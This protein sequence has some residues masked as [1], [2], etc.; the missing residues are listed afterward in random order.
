MNTDKRDEFERLLHEKLGDYSEEPPLGIYSRVESSLAGSGAAVKD[1]GDKSHRTVWLY[2]MA[3]AAVVGLAVVSSLVFM[4]DG[5]EIR[6]Q[7]S[8]YVAE[9][10]AGQ[11]TSQESPVPVMSGDALVNK[12]TVS[13]KMRSMLSDTSDVVK[14][15]NFL[16]AMAM[17]IPELPGEKV[18]AE[19]KLSDGE[20]S[21]SVKEAMASVETTTYAANN[22]SR[23]ARARRKAARNASR[24][25]EIEDYW[26]NVF[27]EDD[28]ATVRK[29]RRGGMSASLYAGNFGAMQGNY[30]ASGVVPVAINGMAIDNTP[31]MLAA[32]APS[33]MSVSGRA[34]L[35]PAKPELHHKMPVSLG[36][37]ISIPMGERWSVVTG[38][39]YS[40]LYS[41][42]SLTEFAGYELSRRLHYL[43]LPLGVSYD[44][45]NK[46]HFSLYLYGG[47]MLEKALY[48]KEVKKVDGNMIDKERLSIKGVQPSVNASLGASYRITPAVGIYFEPGVSY[49]F[50]NLKQPSSYRTEHPTNVSLK[51]GMKF[52]LE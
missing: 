48:G 35:A 24:N 22:E 25:K 11:T 20:V 26:R 31:M 12:P 47:G 42:S 28:M 18:L 1:A 43:G 16:T 32:A 30:N 9:N 34:S 21:G 3:S 50:E 41:K 38:L 46:G 8:E 14:R 37:N 45:W 13:G 33:G 29:S 23:A 17:D 27:E 39:S 5:D 4:H 52:T 44:V 6:P 40:Y 51:V 15:N 7:L 2:A 19:N 10:E 36:V 49:Y